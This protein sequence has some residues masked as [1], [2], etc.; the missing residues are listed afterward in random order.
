MGK[1]NKRFEN[2]YKTINKHSADYF[3]L[4]KGDYDII[5]DGHLLIK[6][7]IVKERL[8]QAFEAGQCN[9]DG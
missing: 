2:W 6:Q 4:D 7:E 9:E 1:K 5:G 3:G 8:K